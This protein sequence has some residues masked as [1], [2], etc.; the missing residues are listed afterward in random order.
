VNEADN[1]AQRTGD[2]SANEAENEASSKRERM[3]A[4]GR[5]GGKRSGEVRNARVRSQ[6]DPE[7]TPYL[8]SHGSLQAGAITAEDIVRI[9]E[10]HGY[11][12]DLRTALDGAGP[13]L[14]RTSSSA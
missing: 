2:R 14:R 13:T 4:L 10:K 8:R 5:L 3:R 9:F 1:E 6:A 11:L 12:E 7:T